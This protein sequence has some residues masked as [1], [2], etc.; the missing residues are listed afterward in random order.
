M[1]HAVMFVLS[2]AGLSGMVKLGRH[3][4]ALKHDGVIGDWHPG[5]WETYKKERAEVVF[6]TAGDAAKA[7]GSWTIGG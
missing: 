7:A 6:D 4:D 1:P 5:R 2:P 3:L